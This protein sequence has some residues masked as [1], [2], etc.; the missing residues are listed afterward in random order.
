MDNESSNQNQLDYLVNQMVLDQY[1]EFD[2]IHTI[3]YN[4]VALQH[5][6]D[7]DGVIDGD[8]RR[9]VSEHN[10]SNFGF[11][12]LNRMC[13]AEQYRSFIE[14]TPYGFALEGF[15]SILDWNVWSQA[16]F[17]AFFPFGFIVWSLALLERIWRESAIIIEE[18]EKLKEQGFYA[19]DAN[20]DDFKSQEDMTE[21][22]VTKY[23]NATVK[24]YPA[25]LLLEELEASYT[26]MRIFCD[27]VANNTQIKPRQII[28]ALKKLGYIV[29]ETRGKI[30]R[31]PNKKIVKG[32]MQELGY[33]D[34]SFIKQI[35]VKTNPHTD[36][37]PVF[38]KAMEKVREEQK[39]QDSV[40]EKL[41]RFFKVE[42]KEQAQKQ[43]KVAIALI[44]HALKVTLEET[45]ILFKQ[46]IQL[47]GVVKK[48]E[49]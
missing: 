43:D 41:K 34:P 32:T 7:L 17:I 48:Y 15:E 6:M 33:G 13:P 8:L 47:M 9:M 27:G 2:L 22:Q 18:R 23:Q 11:E 31:D 37:L 19:P 21:K 4:Y 3:H 46:S 30:R 49:K 14:S 24:A 35:F 25:K 44:S 29:D 45:D 20:P 16:A 42:S 10:L 1:G 12:D 28:P 5:G 38:I 40:V 39:K 26:L 36:L